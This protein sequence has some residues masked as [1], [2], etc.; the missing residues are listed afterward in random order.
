MAVVVA[1]EEAEVSSGGGGSAIIWARGEGQGDTCAAS[2]PTGEPPQMQVAARAQT[3]RT[4]IA[5]EVVSPRL[6]R[7]RRKRRDRTKVAFLAPPHR[8]RCTRGLFLLLAP[9]P[10]RTPWQHPRRLL[11]LLLLLL[12]RLLLR[13]RPRQQVAAVQITTAG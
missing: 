5:E 7:Q 9:R 2:A 10:R 8:R 1:V 12:L 6:G 13:L 4:A 3:V 11:L